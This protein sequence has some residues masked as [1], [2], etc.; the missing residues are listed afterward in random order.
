MQSTLGQDGWQSY[1]TPYP[2]RTPC[3]RMY[4]ITELPQGTVTRKHLLPKIHN[5][6]LHNP[7]SN[8]SW[9]ITCSHTAD[10]PWNDLDWPIQA[11]ISVQFCEFTSFMVP[12]WRDCPSIE[13]FSGIVPN[14]EKQAITDKLLA[15]KPEEEVIQSTSLADLKEPNSWMMRILQIH[16]KFN[17][18]EGWEKQ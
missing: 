10:A 9:W 8:S 16:D 12:D 11:P 17:P 3:W 4:D 5:F 7:S 2:L 18:R 13:L 1:S 6:Y 14:T 15:V